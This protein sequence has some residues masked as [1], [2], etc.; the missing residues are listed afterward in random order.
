[1]RGR[2]G[3]AKIV[4]SLSLF[5]IA[6]TLHAQT[7]DEA[8]LKNK[9]SKSAGRISIPA[10]AIQDAL[11]TKTYTD[12]TSGIQYVYLQQ[13]YKGIPVYNSIKT[14]AFKDDKLVYSSGT[15]ID[16]TERLLPDTTIRIEAIEAIKKAAAHLH[17]A[18]T[19]KNILSLIKTED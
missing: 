6:V 3:A 2:N 9:I 14:I 10:A 8:A 11:I 15:W 13:T 4:Y 17:L 1:M 5:F 18:T 12:N 19:D 7:I 16:K